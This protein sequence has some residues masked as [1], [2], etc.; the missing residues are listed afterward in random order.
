MSASTG[1]RVVVLGGAGFVGRHVCAE[2]AS[3]G[4]DVMAVTWRRVNPAVAKCVRVDLAAA[5]D[6][7]LTGVLTELGPAVVVNCA[8]VVWSRSAQDMRR[9]NVLLTERVLRALSGTP[10]RPRLVQVGSVA[11][12]AS[13][14]PPTLLSE[15]FPLET[16]SAY[17]ST[18]AEASTA[19]LAAAKDGRIDGIVLRVAQVLGAGVPEESLLGRVAAQLTAPA[20][21]AVR[22][23]RLPPLDAVRDFVDAR[24]TAR[25]VVAAAVTTHTGRAINIGRGEPVVVRDLVQ[26]LVDT[27]AVPARIEEHPVEDDGRALRQTN[28]RWQV[29]HNGLARSLLGWR[30]SVSLEDSIEAVWVAASARHPFAAS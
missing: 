20:P 28:S 27:S 10:G 15:D 11:E 14:P 4:W 21:A 17:G 29:V 13:A 1:D 12:Y 5:E 3:A 30:P 24:D 8:G 22:V 23:V 25:A 7:Q 18:K 6:E 19:V 9:S 16:R 2:F 26:Q